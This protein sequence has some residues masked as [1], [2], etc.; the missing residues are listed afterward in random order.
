MNNKLYLIFAIIAGVLLFALMNRKTVA[1]GNAPVHQPGAGSGGV[2]FV[3]VDQPTGLPVFDSSA[4]GQFIKG[5]APDVS[6]M[7]QCGNGTTPA[8]N[9]S[10]GQV[11]C[12]IPADSGIY[13]QA[14]PVVAA[15]TFQITP[16]GTG[17]N[18]VTIPTSG[19]TYMDQ[20]GTAGLLV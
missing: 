4:P 8:I 18:G 1:A 6:G 11:Y 10:D 2:N 9:A 20:L 3:A 19:G 7:Y 13:P 16:M 5:L 12:V 17:P 14:T 15:T